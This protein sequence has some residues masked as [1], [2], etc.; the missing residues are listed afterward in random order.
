MH[1]HIHNKIYIIAWYITYYVHTHTYACSS[2]VLDAGEY[3][4][5]SPLFM[6]NSVHNNNVYCVLCTHIYICIHQPRK[7]TH[8]KARDTCTRY[9]LDVCE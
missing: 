6:I 9:V 7:T 8:A 1:T 5:E 2:C 4:E 3:L